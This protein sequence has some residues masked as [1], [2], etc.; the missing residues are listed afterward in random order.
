MT[1][2]PP[3]SPIGLRPKPLRLGFVPLTDCAPLVLAY[4]LGLFRKFGMRVALQRELGWATIRDKLVY[5]QLDAAHALGPMPLAATLG[6]GSIPCACLT[7]LVLNLHGN[8]ITLSDDL[9]H[10]G[11]RDAESLAAVARRSPRTKPLTFGAVARISSHAFL[12]RSWLVGAGLV[13]QRDFHIVIVPPPQMV[14]NLKAGHLDGFCAGEPWNSLAVQAGAGWCAAISAELAA[15]HP[16]KVLMV[17]RDFAEHRAEEHV[18]LLAALLEGAE[19][20]EEADNR[21]RLVKILA[22]PQYVGVPARALEPGLGA[23][24]DFG[25]G[26]VRSVRDFTIFNRA[27]A[28]EP[29][30]DVAG[31][32]LELLR[33]TPTALPPSRLSAALARDVFR[34]DIFDEA[35]RLRKVDHRSPHDLELLEN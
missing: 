2:I 28:N 18:A 34:L 9:W 24:F 27:Q 16:E 26:I 22:R 6:L 15:R 21:D 35:S 1:R 13:P 25:H 11:V 7:A 17:R 3:H 4:E 10:R 19:F 30:P 31:W 29:G 23:D 14:A 33:Q 32:I 5:G 8:A 20:C 12:V